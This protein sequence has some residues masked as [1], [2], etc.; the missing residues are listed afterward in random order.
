MIVLTR[1]EV[2]VPLFP[3]CYMSVVLVSQHSDQSIVAE[4]FNLF[5]D[6]GKEGVTRHHPIIIIVH[7]GHSLKYIA[8]AACILIECVSIFPSGFPVCYF[9]LL[10]FLIVKYSPSCQ[11]LHDHFCCTSTLLILVSCP[12][13]L[14]RHEIFLHWCPLSIWA[15][16]HLI[17]CHLC[18]CI[19]SVIIFLPVKSDWVTI[20]KFQ[21]QVTMA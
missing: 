5:L 19:H 10:Q 21:S 16:H 3:F 20:C 11:K 8:A 6:V 15:G 17:W 9:W 18:H 12:L 13:L 4:L 14:D 1:V 2:R 7:T